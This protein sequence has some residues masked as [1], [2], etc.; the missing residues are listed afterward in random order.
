M[1]SNGCFL[2]VRRSTSLI[3]YLDEQRP[4]G[5]EEQDDRQD[6]GEEGG[7]DVEEVGPVL[8]F[9]NLT[10]FSLR[11]RLGPL[12]KRTVTPQEGASDSPPFGEYVNLPVND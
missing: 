11:L 10:D 4:P 9:E 2:H 3:A 6:V 8:A 1:C 7:G 12:V 5:D